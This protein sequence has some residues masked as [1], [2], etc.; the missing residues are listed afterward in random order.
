MGAEANPN[1]RRALE[2]LLAYAGIVAQSMVRDSS[3]AFL[4][5]GSRLERA[6]HTVS[7]LRHTMLERDDGPGSEL[8]ADTVL[9]AGESIITHR[10]R[11]AA[12]TGPATASDSVRQLLVHDPTNPRS[13]AH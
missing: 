8:V 6:R 7:L 10:R 9:R 11:A 2:S 4:D 3:W 1:E 13:V 5:A 12:G